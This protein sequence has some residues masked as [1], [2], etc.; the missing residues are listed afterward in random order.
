MVPS[1]ATRSLAELRGPVAPHGERA[2]TFV[3]KNQ[4]GQTCLRRA[5]GLRLEVMYFK[6]HTLDI[7]QIHARDITGSKKIQKECRDA[8]ASGRSLTQVT[9]FLWVPYL[10][11]FWFCR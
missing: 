3:Q 9:P 8:L 1:V 2:Q 5:G 7:D 4:R 11:D 6:S 10:G